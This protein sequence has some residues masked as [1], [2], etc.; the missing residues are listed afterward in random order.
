MYRF[1]HSSGCPK[2]GP[3]RSPCCAADES[4]STLAKFAHDCLRSVAQDLLYDDMRH[5]I[6]RA[7]L[8]AKLLSQIIR[9]TLAAP[10][11]RSRTSTAA[12]IVVAAL[13]VIGWLHRLV[14]EPEPLFG[15]RL[16]PPY[17]HPTSAI[18]RFEFGLGFP[19]PINRSLVARSQ[20]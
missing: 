12:T 20:H 10:Y 6:D 8:E 9:S 18:T 15:R 16:Y 2:P 3:D 11:A 19:V 1:R 5:H 13:S 7:N 17:P 4:P 14:R